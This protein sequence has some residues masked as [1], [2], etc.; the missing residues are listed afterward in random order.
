MIATSIAN[1]SLILILTPIFL[2]LSSFSKLLLINAITST[3]RVD[4]FLSI[5]SVGECLANQSFVA[6]ITTE[7]FAWDKS[8]KNSFWYVC[9]LKIGNYTH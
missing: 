4:K 2:S 7:C 5:S 8:L 3:P 1:A 6:E 9:P